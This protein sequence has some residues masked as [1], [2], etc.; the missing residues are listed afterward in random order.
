MSHRRSQ[1]THALGA[2]TDDGFTLVE[3]VF[4]LSVLLISLVG[5]GMGLNTGSNVAREIRE[6]EI[7]QSQAQALV[8]SMLAQPFGPRPNQ[9]R[10]TNS[11]TS[12]STPTPCLV[13]SL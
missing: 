3:V 11:S 10:A 4:G 1:R 6:L 7:V 2:R 5:V 12:S 13:M 9:T 8:D